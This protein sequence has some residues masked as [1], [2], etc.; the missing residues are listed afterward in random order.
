MGT[1]SRSKAIGTAWDR[2]A[3]LPIHPDQHQPIP[4]I[5]EGIRDPGHPLRAAAVQRPVTPNDQE[6]A[7]T[8]E[9]LGFTQ[10]PW[11]G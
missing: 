7:S 9:G 8:R 3:P 11:D 4:A 6:L 5:K 2:V 10:P 1:L